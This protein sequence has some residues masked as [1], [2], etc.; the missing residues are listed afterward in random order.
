MALPGEPPRD[1]GR[2]VDDPTTPN[3]TKPEM[4]T[5]ILLALVATALPAFA[6]SGKAPAPVAP[7]APEASTIS[8]DFVGAGWTRVSD[9][10]FG[11][12]DTDGY[13]IGLSKTI[14]GGLFGFAS[15]GQQFGDLSEGDAALDVDFTALSFGAGYHVGIAS[16]VDFVVQ[17][18]AGYREGGANLTI[19]GATLSAQ[20]SE[21]GVVAATG[22]RIALTNWLELNLFYTPDYFDSSYRN[23]GTANLIFRNIVSTVDLVLSGS[24]DEETESFGAGL[25]YNF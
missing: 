23:A 7:P 16:N 1:T 10:L 24:I 18:G 22:F 13:N 5:T 9:G 3:H 21:W 17:V 4:K 12:D 11:L 14:T 6:G 2:T 19:P 25:R 8:Y 15:F 20:G